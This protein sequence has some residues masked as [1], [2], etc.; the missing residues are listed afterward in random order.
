MDPTRD[1]ELRQS[2]LLGRAVRGGPIETLGTPSEDHLLDALSAGDLDAARE[3]LDYALAERARNIDAFTLWLRELLEIGA[4]RVPD[5]DRELARMTEAIGEGVP[6]VAGEEVA[7]EEL[8][9]VREGLGETGVEEL[10]ARLSVWTE[11][12]RALHD[13]QTDWCWALLSVIRAEVGEAAM[14]EVL[15]ASLVPWV[16][17]RYE[18]L[19]D[20]SPRERLELTAEVMRG[21]FGGRSRSG[22]LEVRDRGDHWEVSFDP[23]GTG[24]RML[25]GDRE[26]SPRT[27]PPFRFAMVEDAY[28]WT[29]NEPGKCLYCAHCS[30]VN[31]ILPIEATGSPLRVTRPPRTPQDSCRWLVYK[32]ET[33]VPSEAFERVGKQA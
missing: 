26:L 13:A 22:E 5:F 20:L 29:W 4:A 2:R 18:K 17:E 19:A 24:G 10:A 6:L 12:V 31:E 27:E 7:V 11:A 1:V 14:E 9:R 28:D 3:W 23:C 25:R 8:G 21:H 15:R 33:D 16:S 32:S 30:L